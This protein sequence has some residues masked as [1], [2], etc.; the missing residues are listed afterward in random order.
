[1][2]IKSK[3]NSPRLLNNAITRLHL[4]QDFEGI[5][6]A[7][8]NAPAGYG[9]T[10]LMCEWAKQQEQEQTA[11]FSID[12]FD[13]EAQ[14][15][16]NYFLFSLANLESVNC[17][18]SLEMV[19]QNNELDLITLFS[20]FFNE[21]AE[22]QTP[23]SIVLDDFHH[24][25]DNSILQALSF[26]IKHM[27]NNWQIL[28][29]TR[30]PTQLPVSNLRIKQ[31]LFELTLQDLAFNDQESLLFFENSLSFALPSSVILDLNKHV[32]GWPTALQ[33]T[34]ILSKNK[35]SF[36]DYALQ[37]SKNEHIYLWDYFDEEVFVHLPQ[38]LQTLL[39]RIAPLSKIN[40]QMINQL[41]ETDQ[42]DVLLTQ[43]HK[44]S[45][46]LIKLP[47][48]A[49]W[50]TCNSF[51]K[52]FL[53]HKSKQQNIQPLTDKDIAALWLKQQQVAEALPYV[54][55]SADQDLIISLLQQAGWALFH[56]G[57]F[58]HLQGC[59]NLIKQVIWLHPE[60]V[61]LKAWML[62]SHHQHY[63]VAP[64]ISQ[65]EKMF[66]K[67]KLVLSQ[68]M[69]SEFMVIKAQISINQGR[70]NDALAQAKET[71][72]SLPNPSAR[73]NIVA[74]TIIGE[75][76][77]CLGELDLAYQYFQEVS[78]LA[79]EQDMFQSIIW[80]LYQQAEILQA[81][82]RHQK[83]EDHL[84][85]AIGL[86]KKHHLESLPLYAFPL[87][88]KVQR[89]YQAGQFELAEQL[90]EQALEVLKPQDEQ[91]LLYTYTLQTKVALEQG[92][93]DQATK[94]IEEIE[95]LLRNQN[96]HTDWIAS[97]NY[98]RLKYWRINNDMAA[99]EK[100]LQ[101]APRPATALNHFDQCH[102]RNLIRAYIKLGKFDE[103]LHIAQANM[104][105]AKQCSL[106][107]ETNRNLILL[108]SI[109]TKLQKFS[110]AKLHLHQAVESSLYTGL[111]TCFVRESEN[112]KPIY[113]E[114]AN[115]PSMIDSVKT[116]LMKLLTLSGINLN[117]GPNNPF[118][119]SAVLKIIN[120]TRTPRLVKNIPLTPRE[121]QV[122]GLIHSGCRNH[123]IAQT[124]GVAP[125][126][127]KS[128]IRNVYQK[129]GLEDRKE[130]LQLSEQLIAL[131]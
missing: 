60:L 93:K 125:T 116:K 72:L 80:S 71:L 107:M 25:T 34:A 83:A 81:Q 57:Q 118:D 96:Y 117:E 82:S 131:I 79:N 3:L 92:K 76:Y 88:F 27:P 113:Q 101:Q 40:A 2:L 14:Q 108:T 9:K 126:T 70:I 114:L 7:L 94:L 54:I 42:G 12:K 102:N 66:A 52:N 1:M 39:L 26:F 120:H 20:L 29:A 75:A 58:N 55:R 85:K 73:T 67:H 59:F 74:Q 122:L 5:K 130:A 56:D 121:W 77:H 17:P 103:A 99:I 18:A 100:W 53:L 109:E 31:Q 24:I 48:Q 64:L 13:N 35:E 61:I 36:T 23:I 38:V 49:N 129:L 111:D 91:W 6:L 19:K 128:H 95:R 105:D 32:M 69:L 90:C 104:S 98:A 15:F 22:S 21:S 44:Q 4:L 30:Y 16:A 87:H 89:A 65:A 46:L 62:Q 123:E 33:L 8:I 119:S 50:Y 43:L 97:A 106:Q 84:Q 86:I 45:N 37:I 63:K 112:L 127:I 28:I 41:C 110:N 11:W 68:E 124:M 10:S 78:L 115:D 51:F 47:K